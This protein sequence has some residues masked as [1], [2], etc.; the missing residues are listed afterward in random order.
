MMPHLL[1]K[2]LSGWLK[3]RLRA[4]LE[5]GNISAYDPR[6]LG[7]ETFNQLDPK[8][9]KSSRFLLQDGRLTDDKIAQ[10]QSFA[11]QT[12]QA[13]QSQIDELNRIVQLPQ[14]VTGK[15]QESEAVQVDPGFRTFTQRRRDYELKCRKPVVS[16]NIAQIDS[17][18]RA[19]NSGERKL[20]E[21]AEP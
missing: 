16:P 10:I 8:Y 13:L 11:E 14:A 1:L 18:I 7:I 20:V 2:S 5:I 12:V 6:I 4:W 3:R 17:N 9:I 15:K 19:I 21:N